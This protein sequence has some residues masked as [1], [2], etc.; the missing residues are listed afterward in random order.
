MPLPITEDLVKKIGRYILEGLSE[1]ESCI[2]SEVSPSEFREK[3]EKNEG[4]RNYIEE[5]KVTFK[6]NHLKEIQVKRSVA[7]SQWILE[8]L[9]PEEFGVKARSNNNNTINIIAQIIRSIQNDEQQ[10]SGLVPGNRGD[11]QLGNG[12]ESTEPITVEAIL[13]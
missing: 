1:D 4:L 5:K 11:I 6:Y 10:H 12:S 7:T 13:K 2:I 3:K 9:R 8:K